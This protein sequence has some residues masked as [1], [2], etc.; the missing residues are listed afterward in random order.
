MSG[1][2]KA[3]AGAK[4]EFSEGQGAVYACRSDQLCYCFVTC[5][6]TEVT[7][8]LIIIQSHCLVALLSLFKGQVVVLRCLQ[9]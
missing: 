1:Q 3:C 5:S 2:G 6:E 9:V 7:I 4:T 8:R